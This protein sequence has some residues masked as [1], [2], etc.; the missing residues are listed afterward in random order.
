MQPPEMREQRRR[1]LFAERV[2]GAAERGAG[3]CDVV[4]EEPRFGQDRP[5]CELVGS[6]QRGRSQGLPE[7]L[8]RL[9][10]LSALERRLRASHDRLQGHAD[11]GRSIH[12]ACG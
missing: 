2:G 10:R 1:D 11:H 4:L 12:A 3:L 8:R 6:C 7:R 5:E 9:D